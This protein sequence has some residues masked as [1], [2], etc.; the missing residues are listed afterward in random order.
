M[1]A[2]AVGHPI[3]EGRQVRKTYLGRDKRP[4][5]ALAG[6]DVAFK[7]GEI[8]LLVGPSGCGKTTLL[9]IIAG[10]EMADRGASSSA[11]R[12]SRGRIRDA[13]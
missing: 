4:T 10:F 11:A 9:N 2:G 7:E 13:A 6:I 1:G 3:I 5:V 12:R 8:T